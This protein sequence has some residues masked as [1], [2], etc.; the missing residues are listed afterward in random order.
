M[1]K[2][3]LWAHPYVKGCYMVVLSN[4]CASKDED[5]ELKQN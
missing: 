5:K 2:A 4:I 3:L 1:I